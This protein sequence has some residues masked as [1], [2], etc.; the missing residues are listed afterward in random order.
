MYQNALTHW[1][2]MDLLPEKIAIK[3]QL[4]FH[5]LHTLGYPEIQFLK[6]LIVSRWRNSLFLF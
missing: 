3:N 6:F 1:L 4:D 5:K 2:K